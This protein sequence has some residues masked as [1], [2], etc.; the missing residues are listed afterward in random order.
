[1]LGTDLENQETRCDAIMSGSGNHYSS[2]RNIL[3][4]VTARFV[5]GFNVSKKEESRMTPTF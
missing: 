5:D 3:K 1:M 2:S 4:V